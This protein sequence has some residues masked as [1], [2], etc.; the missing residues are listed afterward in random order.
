MKDD[1]RNTIEKDVLKMEKSS[2][3]N[4]AR[5]WI[6]VVRHSKTIV[7]LYLFLYVLMALLRPAAA[8]LWGKY[9]DLL[10]LSAAAEHLA[11]LIVILLSYYL[12]SVA[13]GILLRC[14]EGQEDIEQLNIVQ[15]NRF[16]EQV[17]STMYRKLGKI[18]YEYW[19]I[20][21]INN[22]VSQNMTFLNDKWNGISRSIMQQSYAIIAK[23]VSVIS[24]FAALYVYSPKLCIVLAIIPIPVFISVLLDGKLRFRFI[25]DNSELQRKAQYFQDLM[26]GNGAKEIRTMN[27]HDFF[28]GKWK[29]YV[30]QYAENEKKM[31]RESTILSCVNALI[32]N[33]AIV[34][35]CM[36]AILLM[37]SSEITVGALGAVLSMIT[38]LASDI[39]I[40][41]TGFALLISKK[42]EASLFFGIM[43]LKE[44]REESSREN[45]EAKKSPKEKN[46][47]SKSCIEFQNVVYHYP[48]TDRYVLDGISL[49]IKEGEKVALVG[50]NGAGKTTFVGLLTGLLTPSEGKIIINGMEEQGK[51]D[52]FSGISSVVQ[53]PTQYKTFTLGDN[54]YFGDTMRPRDEEKI[55]KA[56]EFS[57]IEGKGKE[58]L[59][60]KDVGGSDLSGGQWQKLAISRAWYRDRNLVVLDEPTSNL[61]PLSESKIFSKYIALG[62]NKTVVFVTHRISVASLAQRIIVFQNGKIVGDGTHEALMGVNEVYTKL[63]QEQAKWYNR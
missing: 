44:H 33:A 3:K 45:L 22:A 13:E 49:S 15:E 39:R 55:K 26:L 8:L 34:A 30:R 10:S 60:G 12:I 27:L 32:T 40:L 25:K 51:T 19:E 31:Y 36:A 1:R 14:I 56:M 7:F 43:D 23:T 47:Q 6:Y 57:E 17:L 46:N 37:V 2:V 35:A 52:H 41:F 59:L 21:Q 28:F 48:L 61:D 4:L 5:I 20:P 18:D 42:N 11:E 63:Y 9:V 53:T 24:I 54:I 38:T 50:E 29:E 16:Q 58:M 62:E